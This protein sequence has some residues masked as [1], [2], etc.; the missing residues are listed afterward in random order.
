MTKYCKGN[1]AKGKPTLSLTNT[2]TDPKI[3]NFFLKKS[4]FNSCRACSLTLSQKQ[5]ILFLISNLQQKLREIVI[6][7]VSVIS[8]VLSLE[9]AQCYQMFV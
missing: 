9:A 7:I 4:L 2:E 6:G 5:E 3:V 1:N 8:F